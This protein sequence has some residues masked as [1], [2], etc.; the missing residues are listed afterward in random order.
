MGMAYV[1]LGVG[2]FLSGAQGSPVP[3]KEWMQLAPKFDGKMR[4]PTLRN[5]DKR[6]Y[7]G[8]VKSYMHNGYLKSLKE[9]VH[10]YNTRDTMCATP[11]DPNVKKTCWPAPEVT[12]NEDLTVGNLGLSDQ[13]ENDIV[14]FMQTLT[15]GYTSSNPAVTAKMQRNIREIRKNMQQQEARSS[16]PNRTHGSVN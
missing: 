5:V 3:D 9:V 13:D 11:N 16:N 2:A 6:P 12:S 7:P 10:F 4:V 14:A 8:F 15:D 1:D